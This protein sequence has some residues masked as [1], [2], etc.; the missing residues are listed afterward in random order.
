[1]GLADLAGIGSVIGPIAQFGSDIA[2]NVLNQ[3]NMRKQWEREDSSVQRRVQ[4]LVKA[5]LNPVLAAGQGASSSPPIR[6]E[7]PNVDG[8]G[9]SKAIQAKVL[10]NQQRM[11]A[12]DA[13]RAESEAAKARAEA[14]VAAT[15]ASVYAMHSDLL[16]EEYK[17]LSVGEAKALNDVLKSGLSTQLTG[18][19][20]NTAQ[21]NLELLKKFGVTQ[22][23]VD[24][25]S[26]ILGGASK[27]ANVVR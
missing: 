10:A 12:A 3:R 2:T 16:P 20:L 17:G 1:M 26:G 6:I 23:W 9:F 25:V 18:T 24:I 4:D 8:E 5:G 21:F 19:N 15:T 11:T 27:A 14:S 22:N 7:S 13:A